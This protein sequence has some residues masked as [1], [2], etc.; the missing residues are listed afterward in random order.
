MDKI[1][2]LLNDT[3]VDA[4][5]L[6]VSENVIKISFLEKIPEESI[7]LSGFEILNEN[8]NKN[9]TGDYYYLYN[10]IYREID[11]NTIMLSNDGSIY[12]KT[13]IS[14]DINIMPYIP[15]LE[16]IKEMKLLELSTICNNNIINGIDVEI[17]GI[18]EHFSYKDEDQINIKE[19]FDIASQTGSNVYYHS[20]ENALKSYTANQMIS[21]YMTETINKFHNIIYFNQLKTYISTLDA[22]DSVNII[23]YGQSLTGKYLDTYNVAMLQVKENLES[24]LMNREIEN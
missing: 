24:L 21:I 18:L 3:V 5:V 11:E 8:N 10:T 9:M 2:F 6:T 19:L 20:D 1:S 23:V 7:L 4:T 16:E 14:D 13:E 17:D 22:V 15:T 12:K